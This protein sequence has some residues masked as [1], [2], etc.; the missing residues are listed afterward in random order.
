MKLS[1]FRGM[2]GN[3]SGYRGGV[4]SVPKKISGANR[5]HLE[6]LPRIAIVPSEQRDCARRRTYPAYAA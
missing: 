6:G 1:S 4:T 2:M 5:S 3:F